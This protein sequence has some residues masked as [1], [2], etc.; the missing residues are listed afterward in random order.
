MLAPMAQITCIEAK[1]S[2]PASAIPPGEK[3]ANVDTMNTSTKISHR[4][5]V[6]RNRASSPRLFRAAIR[7]ALTPASST[8][9]GAQKCVIQRVANNPAVMLGFAMGS[10]SVPNRKKSRTWSMAM[11]TITSPRS[12]SM[13]SRR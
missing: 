1:T 6:K 4:P 12:M 13:A 7:P 9:T 10:C 3:V 5:R 11:M 2:P 8:K